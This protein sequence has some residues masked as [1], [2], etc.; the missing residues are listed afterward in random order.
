MTA[1]E[2]NPHDP[3]TIDVRAAHSEAGQRHMVDFTQH[4]FRIE[5]QQRSGIAKGDRTPDRSV[6]R[7]R[8]HRIKT[9]GH[10]RVQLFILRLIGLHP[11]IELAVTVRVEDQLIVDLR[12]FTD[13]IEASNTK[14]KH[15][16]GRAIAGKL[17][18]YTGP[19]HPHAAQQPQ[20]FEIKKVA[21]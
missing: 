1:A 14:R 18:V 16:L 8:H 3:V 15:R 4:R 2:R 6:G 12:A 10:P 7:I 20:P 13:G 19:N 17:K 11:R 5:A 21:Q 9:S